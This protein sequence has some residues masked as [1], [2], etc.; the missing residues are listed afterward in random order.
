ML[1][2]VS[3]VITCSSLLLARSGVDEG[4]L[5][6]SHL[7]SLTSLCRSSLCPSDDAAQLEPVREGRRDPA[8]DAPTAPAGQRSREIAALRLRSRPDKVC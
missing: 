6:P 5:S 1:D 3:T 7:S 8:R 4:Q 2:S